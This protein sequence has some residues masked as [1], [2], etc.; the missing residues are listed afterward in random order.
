MVELSVLWWFQNLLS[1]SA[2]TPSAELWHQIITVIFRQLRLINC[3]KEA[4]SCMQT[5][6]KQLQRNHTTADCR[7]AF[8]FSIC[9]PRVSVVFWLLWLLCD[10]KPAKSL[11]CVSDMIFYYVAFCK[12]LFLYCNMQILSQGAL[13]ILLFCLGLQNSNGHLVNEGTRTEQK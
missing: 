12:V 6:R 5:K 7:A 10:W 11:R 2:P 9:N 8:H 4:S 3:G 1:S 13:H